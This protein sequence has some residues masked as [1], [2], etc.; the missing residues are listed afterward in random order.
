MLGMTIGK[1]ITEMTTEEIIIENK[2]IEIGLEVKVGTIIG[3]CIGIVQER[4]IPKIE[5][6][7]ETEVGQDSLT[8]HS[9]EKKMEGIVIGQDQSQGLGLD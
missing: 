1:T 5:I 8:H 6:L 3:I 4:I 7:A 9:E 2:H